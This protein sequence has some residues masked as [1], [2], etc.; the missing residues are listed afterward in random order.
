MSSIL[1]KLYKHSSTLLFGRFS[2]KYL[3][4]VDKDFFI[5]ARLHKFLSRQQVVHPCFVPLKQNQAFVLN[6]RS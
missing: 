1:M 2:I 4:T 5:I 6:D 3:H